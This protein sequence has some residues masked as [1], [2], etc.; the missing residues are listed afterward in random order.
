MSGV[1]RGL[2]VRMS[3]LR[4]IA[5]EF[6]PQKFAAE[7]LARASRKTPRAA[8]NWLAFQNAPDA[9]ALIELMASSNAIADE[10]NALVAA[11][12]RAREGD[13]CPGSS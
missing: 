2:D 12:R 3:L 6:S 7:M 1:V 10:V 13:E 9:V 8:K 4:A 5:A 11:C